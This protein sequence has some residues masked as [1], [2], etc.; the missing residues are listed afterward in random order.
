M[1]G[2]TVRETG[3]GA[4]C[5]SKTQGAYL[6]SCDFEHT[7][8]DHFWQTRGARNPL[9][10]YTIQNPFAQGRSARLPLQQQHR[11]C[12]DHS[13]NSSAIPGR[14]ELQLV[15]DHAPAHTDIHGEGC[16]CYKIVADGRGVYCTCRRAITPGSVL[17]STSACCI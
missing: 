15:R 13:E 9:Q 10:P 2:T 8:G 7:F 14:V 6:S 3:C 5:P 1:M 16:W 11:V 12:L 4:T 17:Y